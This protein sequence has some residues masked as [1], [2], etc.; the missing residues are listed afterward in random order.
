M[1]EARVTQEEIARQARVHRTTVSL[2]LADNPRIPAETKARIKRIAEKLGYTPDPMLSALNAYR[3]KRRP[4]AFHGTLAWLGN[5]EF[6]FDWK[7]VPHFRDYYEG[8]A[9]RARA[10]GFQLEAFDFNTPNMT[11]ARMAG[12][13]RARN[14]TGLLLCPQPIAPLQGTFAWE[15]FSI[16]T[17]GY[18]LAA[19]GVHTVT[20]AHFRA[21]RRIMVELRRRGYKRPGFSFPPGL[22]ERHDY[23]ILAGFLVGEGEINRPPAVP[24]LFG[25]WRSPETLKP[26]IERHKPDVIVSG[27]HLIIEILRELK[28]RV[29]ED[30]G[31]VCPTLPTADTALGG[32]VEDSKRIGA[33]A[34]DQLVSMINRGE[35]GIPEHPLRIHLEGDW[36]P[37]KSL[38]PAIEPEAAPA[39]TLV[40]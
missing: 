34:V 17:F 7:L 21:M 27:N 2:A 20:A 16:V 25:P 15:H 36:Y 30:I 39:N 32:V 1:D 9:A 11:L 13:L 37:G 33:L 35:R 14:V 12:M 28:L 24:P 5:T 10:C 26:W 3:T 19:L 4:S 18:T 8:A 23:N 22:V 31:A 38:R 29:P 40:Y 6:G